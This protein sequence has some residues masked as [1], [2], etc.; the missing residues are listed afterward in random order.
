VRKRERER[1]RERGREGEGREKME[2][3][4]WVVTQIAAAGLYSALSQPAKVFSEFRRVP[5]V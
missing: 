4:M 3:E 5:P 2:D 1:E